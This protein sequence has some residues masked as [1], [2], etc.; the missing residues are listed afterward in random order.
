MPISCINNGRGFW[1]GLGQRL[2]LSAIMVII[3]LIFLVFLLAIMLNLTWESDKKDFCNS[4]GV[5]VTRSSATLKFMILAFGATLVIMGIMTAVY[6]YSDKLN[7]K[8][9]VQKYIM[10]IIFGAVGFI[11]LMF[12]TFIISMGEDVVRVGDG[13]D[14]QVKNW[15]IGEN[16][17][18]KGLNM[19]L[20]FFLG[21]F[22]IIIIS[23]ST[24]VVSRVCQVY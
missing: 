15:C 9:G 14:P 5:E 18:S 20:N 3:S 1:K 24:W 17:T 16:S 10:P 6:T 4:I 19:G 8:T 2:S 13:I 11:T 7:W 12:G 21:L 22:I 23:Y